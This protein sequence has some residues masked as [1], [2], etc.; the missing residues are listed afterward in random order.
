MSDFD[1]PNK[2][3]MNLRRERPA[4]G[5]LSN[6]VFGKVQPQALPLEE[7]IL[8]ALML[9]KDAILS[10]SD[11]LKPETFYSDSNA[12]IYRAIM[13]L[14]AQS[15][16]VD[17]LT[18]AER[19]KAMGEIDR[20]GGYYFLTELTQRVGSSANIEYHAR[21]VAQKKI[22]RDIILASTEAIKIAYE[23]TDDV[24]AQ[25]DSFK[26]NV[27]GI[28]EDLQRGAL[29]HVSELIPSYLRGVESASMQKDG[30]TGTP[31]GFGDLDRLTAGLQKSDFI[32]IA[33][34]P[35]M[36]KSL[37]SFTVARNIALDFRKPVL[38]FSLEMGA[39]QVLNR[40]AS[41]ESGLPATVLQRARNENGEK[42][43]EDQ[44]RVLQEATE[45]IASAPILIDDT[46]AQKPRDI[47]A[48]CQRAARI[49]GEIGGVV[50]DYLQ[51]MKSNEGHKDPT[52]ETN[53]ISKALKGMAKVLNVP[54]I[55]LSQLSRAV[56]IRGGMKRP[57]LSDLRQSGAIEEDADLVGFL[58][59]PE[60]Y[61]IL[62]DE[63]GQSL[64]GVTEL[65]IAKHRNGALDT[66]KMK[67]EADLVRM[68]GQGEFSTMPDRYDYDSPPLPV[69]ANDLTRE[70]IKFEAGQQGVSISEM[71]PK[72]HR[73]IT[74][75]AKMNDEDVPF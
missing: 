15:S 33:A 46:P 23:D 35:S 20:I 49:Y 34:R 38:I 53:A 26:S 43:T 68:I 13:S 64:K 71:M 52:A 51:L 25:L 61:Q 7:V 44:W 54:V 55:A 58:Y 12:T 28:G 62:E 4:N 11:I 74:K 50:I 39:N 21:I 73:V 32:V 14:A 40:I 8:G 70:E 5:D 30:L 27:I 57:Q 19:L 9:E 17:L 18:V 72:E 69:F 16:P 65:I 1:N 36:G 56:E 63:N 45:R 75:P 60:Y 48:K 10:V 29:R 67:M 3:A 31:T 6:Y 59:R 24:F 66:V 41:M 2:Q 37:F 22:Q 42:M 47:L